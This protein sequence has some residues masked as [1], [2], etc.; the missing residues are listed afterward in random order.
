MKIKASNANVAAW[1]NVTAK[2][3]VPAELEKLNELAHN[4]WWAWNHDARSLFTLLDAKLYIGRAPRQVEEF[5]S[6]CI[7]PLLEGAQESDIGDIRV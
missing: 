2:S 5:I 1:K 7:D 4:M 3:N 6:E